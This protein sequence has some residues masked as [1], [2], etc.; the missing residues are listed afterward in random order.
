MSIERKDRGFASSDGISLFG[1]STTGNTMRTLRYPAVL[2]AFLVVSM[3]SWSAAATSKDSSALAMHDQ[4]AVEL[5]AIRIVKSDPV[6][7]Q[8]NAPTRLFQANV[9]AQ[10]PDGKATLDDAVHE[11]AYAGPTLGWCRASTSKPREVLITIKQ[12]QTE[13]APS[14]TSSLPEI[15][16][17]RIG[18]TLVD[19]I[20][21]ICS[22][23][24]RC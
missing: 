8:I 23:G 6:I 12:P 3:L 20:R 11:L 24:G 15:Q 2:S 18:S 10:S 16:E 5:H 14:P 17:F 21:G 9:I 4:R 13:M 1:A 22:S 7:E 19:C